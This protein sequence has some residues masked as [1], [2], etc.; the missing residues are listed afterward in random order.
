MS[1][2]NFVYEFRTRRVRRSV[3]F[4]EF[5]LYHPLQ[6]PNDVASVAQHL[7]KEEA[8]E[9]FLVFMVDVRNKII[10]YE[11]V[12]VGILTGVEVHPREV[13]RPAILAS[14]AAIILV[15]NHPSGDPEMSAEDI[16]LTER[17]ESVG[18][19]IGIPVLDHLVV[20]DTGHASYL[21]YVEDAREKA[22]ANDPDQTQLPPDRD[23]D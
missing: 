20:A 4:E 10:G 13:F 6:S 1:K 8:R 22:I 15:H 17:M 2:K 7:L 14:A 3:A 5:A 16:A 12:A 19:L 9:C 23:A 21:E 11:Q 18:Q